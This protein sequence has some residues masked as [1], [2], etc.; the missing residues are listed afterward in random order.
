M[1]AWPPRIGCCSGWPIFWTCASSVAQPAPLGV[2]QTTNGCFLVAFF[3][4]DDGHANAAYMTGEQDDNAT[5][6]WDGSTLTI[7]SRVFDLDNFTGRLV[8]DRIEADYVW[9]N[10]DTN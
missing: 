8:N 4:G 10:N 3:L 6:S 1:A 2:W 5:W 9:H 7:A